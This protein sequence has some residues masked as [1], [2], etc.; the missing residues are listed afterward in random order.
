MKTFRYVALVV[1]LC[2]M[3][4]TG[5]YAQKNQISYTVTG[6]VTTPENSAIAN[7]VVSDGFRVTTTDKEGFY[8]LQSTNIAKHIF[9]SVPADC[10][11]PHE[12]NIPRFYKSVKGTTSDISVDFTLTKKE[13]DKKLVFVVM[14]DPQAQIPADMKRFT[15]EPI[16]DIEKLKSNYPDDVAFI[17]MTAGDLLWDAPKMYPDYV[18][19]FEQ[20]SFPFYQVIGNHDYDEKIKGNDS[21]SSHYFESYFGPTYYSFNRGDCHFIALDN[22]IYNTR[23]DYEEKISDEQLVWLQQNLKYVDKN[24][25]IVISMH[26]PVYRR[27]GKDILS[28]TSALIKILKGYKVLIVSGHTHRMNKMVVAKDMVDY[29]L[30]PTMGNSWAGD[31]NVDGCPNGYG[32]FEINGNKLVSQYYKA[33]KHPSDYQMNVFPVGSVPELS[34]SVVAHVWNYSESWKVEVYEAGVYKG[35]MTNTTGYDPIA[36]NFFLGTQKPARKPKLEPAKTQNLFYYTPKNNKSEVKV[37]VT[38]CFGNIY[39]EYLNRIPD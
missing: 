14:A 13:K 21:E 2:G 11:V 9:I 17:G 31:I 6:K 24:K 34:K 25:L 23:P 20:L 30:S 22:I 12:G 38:D 16:P 26:S 15:T 39:T 4:T 37:V 35:K 1:F 3:F 33:T 19:A 5:L 18:K 29:T 32:V 10:D 27:D 7:V 8:T 28:N 36:Y